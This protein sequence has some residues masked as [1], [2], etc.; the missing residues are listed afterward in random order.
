MKYAH[1]EKDTNKILGWYSDKIHSEIPTPNI[2]VSDEVW[3]EAINI[4]ANCYEKGK[5]ILKDFRTNNEIELARTQ[6]INSYT[7]SFIAKKYP[8]EKQS[9]AN[10][11]I[12]GEE[13][14]N[15]M[16]SFISNCITL[17]NKAIDDG[18][19]IEDYKIILESE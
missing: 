11:G 7:Q 2:E 4:N 5:F 12:Y 17:S 18:T 1:L 6:N 15:E 13:Y 16:I 14:K 9:S 3:Q 19:S 8:L 10:L